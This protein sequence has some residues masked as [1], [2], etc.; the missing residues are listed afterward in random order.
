MVDGNG[1]EKSTPET[2]TKRAGKKDGN[3]RGNRGEGT[4]LVSNG[5]D[6]VAAGM[7]AAQLAC[8]VYDA[9]RSIFFSPQRRKCS[10][11][12]QEACVLASRACL[13]QHTQHIH[14]T[15]V[16]PA[17]LL[18]FLLCVV[19]WCSATMVRT[20]PLFLDEDGKNTICISRQSREDK[21]ESCAHGRGGM[22]GGE[23]KQAEGEERKRTSSVAVRV[24]LCA[25][26]EGRG[27]ARVRGERG[28]EGGWRSCARR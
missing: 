17:V 5:R 14:T 1:V 24:I 16:S 23:E 27:L 13:T 28:R 26:R 8:R 3:R 6:F 4:S 19:S 2:D 18:L 12:F 22:E 25:R 9:S 10:L 20:N 11:L 7:L 15:G 21:G